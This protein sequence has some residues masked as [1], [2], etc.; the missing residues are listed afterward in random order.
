MSELANHL[1]PL[2]S[3]CVPTYNNEEH[4][5]DTLTSILQQTYRHLEIIISDDAS[6]DRT[7]EIVSSLADE[8]VVVI[9]NHRNIGAP[10]NWFGSLQHA[11]G[12][13]VKIVCADDLLD[14]QCVERQ[15][16]VLESLP[17]HEACIIASRRRLIDGKG[18]SIN[19]PNLQIAPGTYAGPKII[20]RMVRSGTNII[21]EPMAAMFRR[22]DVQAHVH[23]I[24]D[25]VYMMDVQIYMDVLRKGSLVM[26]PSTDCSFRVH[27]GSLSSNLAWKQ[28]HSFV[29]FVR[30]YRQGNAGALSATDVFIGS[31]MCAGLT[32]GRWLVRTLHL[33][34]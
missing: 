15:V 11:T 1:Q 19:A 27:G 6:T 8:R 14:P 10:A 7:L 13:Y 31:I 32:F 30:A 21:G 2:V 28:M 33:S 4:I 3:I 9:R 26:L 20:K 12:K 18:Q 25:N 22:H 34:S 17:E 5:A 16:E 29:S 24:T 23:G